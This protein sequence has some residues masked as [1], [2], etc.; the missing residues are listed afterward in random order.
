[1]K[2]SSEKRQHWTTY[3]EDTIKFAKQLLAVP[4]RRTRV[5]LTPDEKTA[6]CYQHL[7]S[8]HCETAMQFA[9]QSTKKDLEDCPQ[10]DSR[11]SETFRS[12][13]ETDQICIVI[14]HLTKMLSRDYPLLS[15]VIYQIGK[16]ALDFTSDFESQYSDF[17]LKLM[18][19]ADRL[20]KETSSQGAQKI[21]KLLTCFV[22][23]R[24]TTTSLLDDLHCYIKNPHLL[25]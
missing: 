15:A 20:Y 5:T 25:R 19:F 9:A 11:T 4:T 12:L 3:P 8:Q 18:P 13:S 24:P 21:W 22:G 2:E 17:V 10:I 6:L 14:L 16:S 23:V 7:W 1:M